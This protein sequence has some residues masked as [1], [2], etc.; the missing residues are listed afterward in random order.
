MVKFEVIILIFE[1]E[2]LSFNILEVIEIKQKDAYLLNSGRNFDALSFRYDSDTVLK[3]QSQTVKLKSNSICYV[4]AGV[5]YSRISKRDNLIVI[6][7]NSLNYFSKE[8]EY[9]YPQNTEKLKTLFKD[10]LICWQKKETGYR[11][12]CS[13]ILYAI[14]A[15]IYKENYKETEYDERIRKSVVYITENYTKSDIS[16]KTASEKSNI[17]EVY[18]RK[19]FKEQFGISPKKHIINLRIKHAISLIENGYY[20]LGEISE[21]CGFTDYKY[22][23]TEF[24]R[25]TG[26]KPSKY[27]YNYKE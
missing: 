8:I 20:S 4:P 6:Q 23:S 22:F 18:F 27:Y 26:Y 12:T 16:V 14:F 15:E 5:D 3:N 19:I 1:K 11:Y 24:H 25:I 9:F 7:L 2:K 21:M 17:S 13:S 10:I